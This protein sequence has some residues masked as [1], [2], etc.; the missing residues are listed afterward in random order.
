[1]FDSM[2]AWCYLKDKYGYVPQ[3]FNESE[4]ETFENLPILR[5]KDNRFLASWLH[6][7]K[8][9]AANFNG[10]CKKRWDNQHDSLV[11]F[12]G[13]SKRIRVNAGQFKSYDINLPLSKIDKV[14]F[15]FDSSDIE[16]VKRLISH[17]YGIGKKT[18]YGYGEI[19]SFEIEQIDYNPFEQNIR[20]DSG[21]P[22]WYKV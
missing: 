1:M 9:K 4:R 20:Y 19:E 7:E 8:D 21:P 11:D 17:L 2:L 22:Y 14:W 5:D 18:A 12:K 15:F 3:T 16:E 10:S 13:K 6:Y